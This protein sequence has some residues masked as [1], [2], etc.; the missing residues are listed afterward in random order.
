MTI[1]PGQLAIKVNTG[2]LK[3]DTELFGKMDPFVEIKIGNQT[4][5]TTA[6]T[7]GGKY[8]RWNGEVLEFTITNEQEMKLT[9]F[10]EETVKKHDRVGEAIFFL[11]GVTKGEIKQKPIEI[12]YKNKLAGTVYV[13][14]EFRTQ[15]GVNLGNKLLSG[16]NLGGAMAAVPGAPKPVQQPMQA[17]S[18]LNQQLAS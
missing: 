14:F 5:R 13:D 18:T 10:D 1:T 9:V 8:P 16:L 12:L 7:N 6:H 4:K 2:V 17:Q 15:M 3:R 11:H